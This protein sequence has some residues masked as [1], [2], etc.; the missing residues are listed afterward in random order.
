MTFK[1][2]AIAAVLASATVLTMTSA[3][4]FW[5]PFA[6]DN[7]NNGWGNGNGMG[8][9][10]GDMMGDVDFSMSFKARGKGR[11]NSAY[12]GAYNGANGDSNQAAPANYGYAP[13]RAPVY[14]TAPAVQPQQDAAFKAVVEAQQKAQAEFTQRVEAQRVA[15]QKSFEEMVSARQAE[16]DQRTASV[17]P[18]EVTATSETAAAAAK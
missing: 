14:A 8:D 10:M 9:M 4:A 1:T 5:G 6:S 3:Q 17:T 18:V 15:M 7:F 11:G 13:Y 2:T 12:N 16:W